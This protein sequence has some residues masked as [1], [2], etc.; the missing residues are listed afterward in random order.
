[1]SQ[2]LSDTAA[3]R[4]V[5]SGVC[6]YGSQAFVDVDDVITANSFV[7]ESNQII[8]KCLGKILEDSDQVDISSIL[9]SATELNFHEILNS[10]K[11]LEYLRSIN[12]FP[13]HLE[14]GPKHA[15]KIRKLEFARTIQKRMRDQKGL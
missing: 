7:H 15:V 4:A 10:K 1:M 13:I 8:Y 5:L 2:I 12:N 9:S 3:E 14:N 6:Q 11:E